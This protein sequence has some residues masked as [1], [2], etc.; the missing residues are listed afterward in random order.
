MDTEWREIFGENKSCVQRAVQTHL[1]I[2]FV[3]VW[4]NSL[5][6][7]DSLIL[8]ELVNQSVKLIVPFKVSFFGSCLQLFYN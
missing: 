6:F 2:N 4:L 8:V 1:S 3:E 5:A 7:H